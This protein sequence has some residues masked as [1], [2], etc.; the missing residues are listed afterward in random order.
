MPDPVFGPGSGCPACGRNY[1]EHTAACP[2]RTPVNF[3]RVILLD[4]VPPSEQTLA[5]QAKE[6]QF[7]RLEAHLLQLSKRLDALEEAFKSDVRFD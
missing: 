7:H 2:R 5:L 4:K 3:R 6:A 1:G